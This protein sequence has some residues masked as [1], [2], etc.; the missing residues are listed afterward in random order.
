M[1][2]QLTV[3][4]ILADLAVLCPEEP[5][6]IR[7]SILRLGRSLSEQRDPTEQTSKAIDNDE[8]STLEGNVDEQGRLESLLRCLESP[9]ATS[10]ADPSLR[11]QLIEAFL[12]SSKETLQLNE[13]ARGA[14][15]ADMGEKRVDGLNQRIATLQSQMDVVE[16]RLLEAKHELDKTQDTRI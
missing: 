12:A 16:Q 6:T 5:P 2:S 3:D 4:D 13:A 15:G 10:K 1:S 7:H 14:D 9:D 8:I 11:F